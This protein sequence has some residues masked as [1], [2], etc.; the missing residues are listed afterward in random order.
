MPVHERV[1]IIDAFPAR[2]LP[3][4]VGIYDNH[5]LQ[6]GV[7]IVLQALRFFHE[8]GGPDHHL[9]PAVID[10]LFQFRNRIKGIQPLLYNINHKIPVTDT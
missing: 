6:R 2:T 7:R 9:C 5:G 8:H 10:L 3:G 1:K 4:V